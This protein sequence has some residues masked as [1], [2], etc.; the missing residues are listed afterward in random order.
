[1]RWP[2]IY[3]RTCILTEIQIFK[4]KQAEAATK[5]LAVE[6]DLRFKDTEGQYRWHLN[7]AKL[8]CG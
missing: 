6:S 2:I 7:I 1:M 8:L 5:G 3:K 4:A